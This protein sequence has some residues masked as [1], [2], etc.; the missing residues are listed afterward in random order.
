MII[1]L[2]GD[3]PVR[4]IVCF[5]LET[6]GGTMEMQGRERIDSGRV[7]FPKHAGV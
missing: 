7:G 6:L 3:Q 5:P 1:H 4:S 2:E